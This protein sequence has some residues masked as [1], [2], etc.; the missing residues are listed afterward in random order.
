MPA[1]TVA[2]GYVLQTENSKL[3]RPRTLFSTIKLPQHLRG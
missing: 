3:L 1:L 2:Q